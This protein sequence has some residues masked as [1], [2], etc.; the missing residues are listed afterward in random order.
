MRRFVGFCLGLG[1]VGV[2]AYMALA[3]LGLADPAPVGPRRWGEPKLL[4]T[5]KDSRIA[6]SS[7]LAAS[8]RCPGEFLTHNDSG[9]A[10]R[11][12][13]FDSAG[14][15]LGVFTLEGIE[16]RDWESIEIQAVGGQPTVFVADI[17]DN[18]V[19]Q[20]T[21]RVYR[22]PEPS[23]DARSVTRFDT[24]RLRYPDGPRNSEALLVDPKTGDLYL[25]SKVDEGASE[26]YRASPKGRGNEEL[27]LTKV[28]EFT[29]GSMLPGTQSITGGGFSTDGKHVMVRTYVAAFEFV[30]PEQR[31]LWSGGKPTYVALPLDVQGEALTYSHDSKKIVLSSERSPTPI[32]ELRLLAGPR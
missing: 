25:V 12:F 32:N 31:H 13:R 5:L 21:V 24:I 10:A 26:V 6:E 9:D 23:R 1:L 8:L 3:Y 14:K 29:V 17:G 27:T 7:G 22:F 15:V 4:C 19:D 20:R 30:V 16:A 28:G 2:G 11:V 18:L